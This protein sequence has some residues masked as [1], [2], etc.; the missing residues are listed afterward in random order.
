MKRRFPAMLI[1]FTAMVLGVGAVMADPPAGQ[2]EGAPRIAW[3]AVP[4]DTGHSLGHYVG[5]GSGRPLKGEPRRPE[6]GTWGWDYQGWLIP[7]RVVLQWWHG[8]RDQGGAGAYQTVGP[9]LF[10]A[11]QPAK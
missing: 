5:G 7:R 1:C 4:S 8:R 9:K 11:E 2:I 6:E 10:H 3:W